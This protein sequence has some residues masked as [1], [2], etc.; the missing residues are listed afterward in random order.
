[1][2]SKYWQK[3]EACTPDIWFAISS[4]QETTIIDF[5]IFLDDQTGTV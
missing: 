5:P 2:N 1:M 4:A 3:V